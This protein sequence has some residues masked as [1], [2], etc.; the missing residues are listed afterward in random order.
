MSYTA[1]ALLLLFLTGMRGQQNPV[2]GTWEGTLTQPSQTAL[3]A[4][5][6]FQ[7]QLRQKGDSLFG[8]SKIE[9]EKTEN[10]AEISFRGKIKNDSVFIY[11]EKILS[12][13]LTRIDAYWCIKASRLR[14]DP[15]KQT[16]SG[17]WFAEKGCGP[18]EIFLAR[19]APEKK[20]PGSEEFTGKD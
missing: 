3:A 17:D 2:A 7:L 5:Y 19:K 13:K 4:K 1:L 8:I 10:F 12:K 14:Y 6:P 11:E 9:V 16:L 18:G 20:E 15:G